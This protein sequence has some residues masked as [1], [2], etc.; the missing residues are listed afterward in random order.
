MPPIE[1]PPATPQ[2]A[3]YR[4]LLRPRAVV[5]LSAAPAQLLVECLPED[6][7]RLHGEEPEHGG[8]PTVR[9]FRDATGFASTSTSEVLTS[10]IHE[11]WLGSASTFIVAGILIDQAIPD[12]HMP[13]YRE[14]PNPRK[15][16]NGREIRDPWAPRT[17]FRR[18]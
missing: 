14:I 17:Y 8:E 5:T 9:V 15:I 12:Y 10:V 6:A 18:S 3:L 2:D 16:R 13:N 11:P 1:Q 7:E 4:E